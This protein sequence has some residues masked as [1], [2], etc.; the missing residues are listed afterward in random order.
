MSNVFAKFDKEFD[1]KGLI[2]DLKN[3]SASDSEYKEVP[4]GTYEVKIEKLELVESKTGK[5][6]VSCWMRI[7][8][9]EYKNSILFMNQVIHTPYGLHMAN[10][11]LRSLESCLEVE[12]ESFTQYHNMLLNIHEAVDETYEYAVEYGETKKGFKTFKIVEVFE[13]E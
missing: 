11:F 12:F 9:G 1:V 8:E 3:I 5:P 13:V 10:E 6:M 7:L 4:L 2:E